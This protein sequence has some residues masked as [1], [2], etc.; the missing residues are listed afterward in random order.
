MAM[1]NHMKKQSSDRKEL[2]MS[3]VKPP[4][5]REIPITNGQQSPLLLS[6]DKRSNT[7]IIG[8]TPKFY[9]N[10]PVFHSNVPSGSS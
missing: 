5:S 2:L 8:Q 6:N 7:D 9:S 4:M 10:G 1:Q 3:I